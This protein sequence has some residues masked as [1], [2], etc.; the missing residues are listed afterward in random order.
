MPG[1]RAAFLATFQELARLRAAFDA[2][3]VLIAAV[4]DGWTV[5]AYAHL[6]VGGEPAHGMLG[7][8]RRCDVALGDRDIAPRHLLF[9]ASPGRDLRLR[10][11]D[12]GGLGF[13]SEDGT[14]CEAVVTEG[15]AFLRTGRYHVF[16]FPTGDY[17]P[18]AW[19]PAAEDTWAAFPERVNLAA[20]SPARLGRAASPER[21]PHATRALAGLRC[22][23][24]DLAAGRPGGTLRLTA[25]RESLAYRVDERDLERGLLVGRDDGCD[26]GG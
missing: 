6:P 9:V 13:W 3:G 8:H 17:A 18:F 4:R 7:R 26:L 19:D 11:R 14:R 16:A 2:D 25:D 1:F 20:R 15:L 21:D 22:R 24:R 23:P 10:V 5:E 12:L